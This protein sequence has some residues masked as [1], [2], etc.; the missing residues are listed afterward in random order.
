M[1]GILGESGGAATW[2]RTVA[3]RARLIATATIV[4]GRD[5]GNARGSARAPRRRRL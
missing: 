5:V 2:A 1:P 4:E 3:Q